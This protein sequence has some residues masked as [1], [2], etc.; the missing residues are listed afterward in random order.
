[1]KVPGTPE[2]AEAVEELIY[3]GVNVNVTLLFNETQYR[4]AA[5]AYIRGIERR[6]ESGLDAKVFSV[7]SVFVSRWDTPTADLVGADLKNKLG[8]AC[9]TQCHRAC[10]EIFTSERFKKLETQG[11]HRQKLLMASTSTKDPSLPD[12]LYVTALVAR[13]SI[14]TIPE[15]TLLA[16]ADHGVVNGVLDEASWKEADR[17]IAGFESA[18]V[19]IEDLGASL[20][21][22]GAESFVEA[23]KHL[24]ETIE[25][26]I[27]NLQST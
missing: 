9:A 8:I 26:K 4:L 5:E 11:A 3:R 12:T 15:A 10:E 17:V 23:W 7:A 6:L 25:S 19:D 20:Q 14:D 16:F 21:S 24:L 1:I 27:G 2:G 18:G 13:D 22:D